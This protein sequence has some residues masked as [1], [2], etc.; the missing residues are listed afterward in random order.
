MNQVLI[1]LLPRYESGEEVTVGG[2][3]KREDG[4]LMLVRSIV[5]T[6][7]GAYISDVAPKEGEPHYF[8][9]RGSCLSPDEDSIE[10]IERD[11]DLS[12]KTYIEKRALDVEGLTAEQKRVAVA[13]D[14]IERTKAV[15][16]RA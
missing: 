14:L 15:M 11:K 10:E 8:L 9:V 16:G 4:S 2:R 13:S 6:D 12:V 3:V 1:E 7:E 5:L